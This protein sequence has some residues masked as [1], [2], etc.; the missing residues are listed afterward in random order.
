MPVTKD[1]VDQA[2]FLKLALHL[3]ALKSRLEIDVARIDP[4]HYRF[5][6]RI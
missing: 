4:A 6:V 5:D 1:A 2:L 3:A